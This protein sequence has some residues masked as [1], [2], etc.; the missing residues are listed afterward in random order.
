MRDTCQKNLITP[1]RRFIGKSPDI[2]QNQVVPLVKIELLCANV[3]ASRL[4]QQSLV[5]ELRLWV[6]TQISEDGVLRHLHL[7]RSS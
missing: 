4:I 6:V 7:A 5:L 2:I 3:G 1:K